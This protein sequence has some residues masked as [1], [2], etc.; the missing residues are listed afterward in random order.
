[1]SSDADRVMVDI[2]TLGI[3][4]GESIVSIGAVRFDETGLGEEFYRTVDLGSCQEA[5]LRI[6]ADTLEWWLL[7]GDSLADLLSEGEPLE[8][9]LTD[10]SEYY[11]DATE[12]WAN[13]P[14]FDCEML[15]VA[16]DAVGMTEPWGFRD[17]RDI[18][19]LRNLPGAVEVEMEGT[20]HNALDDARYQA[21]I[22]S[23]TLRSLSNL[24]EM[25]ADE[26][27]SDR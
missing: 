1:M 6:D 23:E 7:Q 14:S 13:S 25:A 10:F 4:P 18:R 12:V 9:V 15:E 24:D 11:G 3:E 27:M 8:D 26:E 5:G 16:Y 22:A 21:R 20:E 2:E 17:E 19:T